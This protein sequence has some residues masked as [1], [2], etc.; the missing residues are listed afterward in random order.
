MRQVLDW[1][2]AAEMYFPSTIKFEDD[3]LLDAISEALPNH[4]TSSWES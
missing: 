2:D 1:M 3:L 4:T